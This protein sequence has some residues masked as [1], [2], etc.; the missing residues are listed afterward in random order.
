MFGHLGIICV[1]LNLFQQDIATSL[2]KTEPG[3]YNG[4]KAFRR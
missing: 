2:K 3:Y 1:L 4:L